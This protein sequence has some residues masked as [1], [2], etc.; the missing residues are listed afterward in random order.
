MPSEE[1]ASRGGSRQ[2][3]VRF[4]IE[5][6]QSGQSAPELRVYLFTHNGSLVDSRPAR[7]ESVTFAID[8]GRDYRVTVGPD[9]MRGEVQPADL[10]GTLLKASSL[11]RD[12]LHQIA[13]EALEFRTFP[14]IWRCWFP[15]CINVHGTVRKLLNPGGDAAAIRANLH[16]H[17]PD[18]SGRSRL[19]IGQ[20]HGD[21]A[22]DAKDAP[23]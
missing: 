16:R 11:S 1:R 14:P 19:H 18:L 8:P 21:P 22:R 23:D 13:P 15:V 20:L 6:V 4:S 9:V 5:G 17:G 3:T 10:A 7:G 12:W 2:L